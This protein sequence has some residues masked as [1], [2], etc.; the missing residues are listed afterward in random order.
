MYISA[1]PSSISMLK[2]SAFVTLTMMRAHQFSLP[3]WKAHFYL[4]QLSLAPDQN[5]FC[6]QKQKELES[7]YKHCSLLKLKPDFFLQMWSS[8]WTWLEFPKYIPAQEY[9]SKGQSKLHI[10]SISINWDDLYDEIYDAFGKIKSQLVI[11]S[12]FPNWSLS[13]RGSS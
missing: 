9:I 10:N 6:M 1:A 13:T 8:Y 3:L 7:T 2:H 12:G 11:H 4:Q 5:I